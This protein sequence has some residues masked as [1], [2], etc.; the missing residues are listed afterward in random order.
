MQVFPF[1]GFG[2]NIIE[3]GDALIGVFPSWIVGE[4]QRFAEIL[5][6][7]LYGVRDDFSILWGFPTALSYKEEGN[8]SSG[9]SDLFVQFEYAFYAKQKKTWTNEFTIVASVFLP[10]GNE[11][12][13]PATGL[14]SPNFFLGVTT[15]HLSV[16]WYFY[17]SGGGFFATHYDNNKIGNRFIYEFGFGKVCTFQIL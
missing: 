1:L 14:G 15:S 12:K 5:P 6:S 8:H 9:F 16:E 13:I 11:C 3:Q 10:T 4:N 7:L 2:E 17:L